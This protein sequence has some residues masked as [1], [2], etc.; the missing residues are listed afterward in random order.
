MAHA[1]QGTR[2]VG[3]GGVPSRPRIGSE[4]SLTNTTGGHASREHK[5]VQMDILAEENRQQREEIIGLLTTAYW[6]EIE[7]SR[8]QL[9]Q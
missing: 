9:G 3:D 8:T 7:R 5:G 1:L 2:D 4:R 6:M